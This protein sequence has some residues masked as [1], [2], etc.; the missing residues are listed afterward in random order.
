MMKTR[1]ID[2]KSRITWKELWIQGVTVE[3]LQWTV[4]SF[5]LN[6]VICGPGRFTIYLSVIKE[7][8]KCFSLPSNGY[9]M[10]HKP[11]AQVI[12]L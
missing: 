5:Y 8:K 3:K 1:S 6:P 2:I 4:V 12:Y 11:L 7:I 10:M 9:I